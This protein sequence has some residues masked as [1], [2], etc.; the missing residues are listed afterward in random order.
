MNIGFPWQERFD[1]LIG[2][3]RSPCFYVILKW[4]V[5]YRRFEVGR[6]KEF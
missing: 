5:L 2:D 1:S 3:F 6:D 4:L